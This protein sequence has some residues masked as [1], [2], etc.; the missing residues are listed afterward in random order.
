M[1]SAYQ[2][3]RLANRTHEQIILERLRLS[4]TTYVQRHLF[5]EMHETAETLLRGVVEV[6][7]GSELLAHR[8]VGDTYTATARHEFP[9]SV[10]QHFK[11]SHAG[12]WWLRWLV[13]RWPVR[14][15]THTQPVRVDFTRYA[16]YPNAT[17]DPPSP[18]GAAVLWERAT[19]HRR[20]TPRWP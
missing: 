7:F 9:A 16:T 6:E 10:W 5:V 20:A 19:E 1:T 12:S 8:L 17:I 3:G 11:A 15:Q 2:P 18:L 4:T 13:D 14:C